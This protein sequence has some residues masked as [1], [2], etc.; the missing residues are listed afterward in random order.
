MI[1]QLQKSI[2]IFH[3]YN[4]EILSRKQA[5]KQNLSRY[6]TAKPCK[7][8][9]VCERHT[10]DGH[11]VECVLKRNR[12]QY[13]KHAA[14]RRA[15]AKQYRDE[16]PEIIL[17]WKNVNPDYQTLWA[18]ENRDKRSATAKRMLENNIQRKLAHSLRRR[19]NTIIKKNK[20]AGSAVKD[21]GCTL[22][23][24]KQY[25]ENQFSDNMTWDNW[26]IVWQ[27]DHRRPLMDFDLTDIEQFQQACHYTNLQPLT[28]EDHKIKTI[29]EI[30]RR[31]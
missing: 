10:S 5:K 6:Y 29:S 23:K 16:H 27:L 25:I 12:D 31:Q 22:E 4:M 13:A 9:H 3:K 26:G 1:G 7:H 24:L 21:L 30:R 19:L 20:R 15:Y 2:P 11:C 28:I 17:R 14:K 8:G 18:R